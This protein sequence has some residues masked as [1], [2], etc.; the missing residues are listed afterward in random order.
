MVGNVRDKTVLYNNNMYYIIYYTQ[1]HIHTLWSANCTY[2]HSY[3]SITYRT[4]WCDVLCRTSIAANVCLYVF[5][6]AVVCVCVR[7]CTIR[8]K[9]ADYLFNSKPTTL[10]SHHF[11]HTYTDDN[12]CVLYTYV[13]FL[14][15]VYL[16]YS[17]ALL[18]LFFFLR[19][20]RCTH[21]FACFTA[22]FIFG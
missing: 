21:I 16:V 10:E 9:Q 5:V 19:S 4:L 1:K 18:L 3:N 17:I 6:E 2:T 22:L 14:L 15:Y 13:W 11:T 7:V 12:T 20:S 8:C